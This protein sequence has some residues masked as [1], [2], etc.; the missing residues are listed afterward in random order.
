MVALPCGSRS[1]SS[2]RLGVRASAAARFTAVVVLPTPPF[3]L[4]MA[5]MRAMRR[6]CPSGS[7]R[8][9]RRAVDYAS[10]PARTTSTR[11]RSPTSPGTRSGCTA[12]SRQPAGSAAISSLGNTPFIASRRPSGAEQ[13]A[14]QRQDQR[15]GGQR[16]RGDGIEGGPGLN[17]SI[18]D[19]ATLALPSLSWRIASRR[20]RAFLPLLSTR[21]TCSEGVAI[22]SGMP[23]Q[24]GAGAQV[25]QRAQPAHERLHRQRVQQVLG[26]HLA[27]VA[28]RGEVVGRVPS[29]EQGDIASSGLASARSSDSA[30]RPASSS[31][32]N[33]DMSSLMGEV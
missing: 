26:D 15:Q 7:Q 11:W 8:R 23:G 14:A 3:W 9:R 30:A 6:A 22:A 32:R 2:T 33:A 21:V 10:E 24:A 25:G 16:A 17:A 28:H 20:K 1:T 29:R 19:S 31:G 18:R 4:A 13:V 27:R 12:A 5:M